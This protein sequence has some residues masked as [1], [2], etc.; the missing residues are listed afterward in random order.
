MAF[1]SSQRQGQYSIIPYTHSSVSTKAAPLRLNPS[2]PSSSRPDLIDSALLRP[3]RLDKS[4]LC[5]MPD[6][7]ERKEVRGYSV[8]AVLLFSS[9]SLFY[10]L[11]WTN[12]MLNAT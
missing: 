2:V 8:Y 11:L 6:I 5:D 4:L 3:G 12:P 1:T 9:F 7:E 10:D